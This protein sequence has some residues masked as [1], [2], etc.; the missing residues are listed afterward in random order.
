MDD[1]NEAEEVFILVL[2]IDNEDID[3]AF[4]EEGGVLVYTI[5]DNNRE[6]CD[7]YFLKYYVLSLY[8]D[9]SKLCCAEYST[10]LQ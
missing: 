5:L 7:I 2:E 6:P 3:F 8:S 1:V 9:C 4:D 10:T